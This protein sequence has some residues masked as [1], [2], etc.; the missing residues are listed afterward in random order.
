[1]LNFLPKMPKI[2]GKLGNQK[3]RQFRER[4]RIEKF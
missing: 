3:I 2:L 4:E 1:M